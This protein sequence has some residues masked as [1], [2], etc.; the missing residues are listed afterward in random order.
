MK[1]AR[2]Q[3]LAMRCWLLVVPLLLL[4]GSSHAGSPSGPEAMEGRWENIDGRSRTIPFLEIRRVGNE[5]RIH[6][7][8][9]CHPTPCD[10]G[11]ISAEAYAPRVDDD[12]LEE[13][14]ALTA[15]YEKSF[16]VTLVSLK[17][18]RSRILE[19]D[20]FTRFRDGSGRSPYHQTVR[21]LRRRPDSEVEATREK[22]TV[23]QLERSSA[24]TP[25]PVTPV[26]VPLRPAKPA[27]TAPSH[28]ETKPVRS[29]LGN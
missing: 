5:Y 12:P 11:E 21:L 25:R 20:L 17:L 8:G 28:P 16:A 1:Y 22:L 2:L 10:W 6:L 26:E 19:L 4:S 24:S 14:I 3:G 18:Q 15:S 23:R 9:S 27:E 13:T 7:W 29:W